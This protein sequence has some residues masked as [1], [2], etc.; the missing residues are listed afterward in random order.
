VLHLPDRKQVQQVAEDLGMHLTEEEI[1]PYCESVR[2][3]LVGFSAFFD[4]LTSP[5]VDHEFALGGDCERRGWAPTRDEDS[6]NVWLYKTQIHPTGSGVLDGTSVALKDHIPVRGVPLSYGSHVMDDFTADFDATIVTRML[7]AGATITGKLNMDDFSCGGLGWG[8]I[9]DFGRIPNPNSPQHITGGSSSGSAVAVAKG[10][11]DISIGGDQGGSVRIPASW[12]GVVGLKPTHG[13]VPHTGIV[14]SDR[15]LDSVGPLT[16][17]VADAARCLFA[18][19]GPDGHDPRWDDEENV[20]P[21]YQRYLSSM[22]SGVQGLRIGVLEEG[23][24]P[25]IEPEVRASVEQALKQLAEAGAILVPVSVPV[26][27]QTLIPYQILSVMGSTLLRQTHFI[28]SGS[29]DF[30]PIRLMKA[31]D[32]AAQVDADRMPPLLKSRYLTGEFAFRSF[33][34]GLYGKAQNARKWFTSQYDQVM[35][36]IDVLALPTTVMRAPEYSVSP[37]QEEAVARTLGL[38][39]LGGYNPVANTAP[40][41]Y[42]G[43]PALTLPCGKVDDLPV[44]LQ[45]VAPKHRED[46]LFRA[47]RGYEELGD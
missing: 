1:G 24:A 13:L 11:V 39:R 41:N 36:T 15:M 45:F 16:R 28:M 2:S 26:H 7:A 35:E 44:G 27:S 19:A 10:E 43:H 14:G 32:K 31:L 30:Y 40:F 47:G 5:D 9:G 37:S 21:D 25:P 33:R 46:L 12:C 22:A 20:L 18:I 23:F 3:Q 34:G 4:R 38:L 29:K 8:G 17:S 42:T 6:D